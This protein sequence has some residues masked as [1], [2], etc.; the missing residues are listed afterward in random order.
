[1]LNSLPWIREKPGYLADE[2]LGP[3]RKSARR[4]WAHQV[5]QRKNSKKIYI[6]SRICETKDCRLGAC[7]STMEEHDRDR[8]ET[9]DHAFPKWLKD[10]CGMSTM[11]L[12]KLHGD[13]EEAMRYPAHATSTA[14]QV[15]INPITW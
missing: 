14:S 5:L 1:M 3:T 11:L 15:A 13:L 12:D 4:W 9:V 6:G 7:S 2:R 8:R 10:L